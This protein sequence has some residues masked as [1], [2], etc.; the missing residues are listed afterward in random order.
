MQRK[1]HQ[2][3]NVDI[4]AMVSRPVSDNGINILNIC[5]FFLVGLYGVSVCFLVGVVFAVS[6]GRTFVA[7]W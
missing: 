1:K 6:S 3:Y 4:L 7:F 2:L 5:I